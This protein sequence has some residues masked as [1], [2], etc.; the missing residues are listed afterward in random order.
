[1]K[2]IFYILWACYC[3]ACYSIGYQTFVRQDAGGWLLFITSPV[4]VPACYAASFLIYVFKVKK[5]HN[6]LLAAALTRKCLICSQKAI[7]FSSTYGD[8]CSTAHMEQF[9]GSS[10]GRAAYT[11]SFKPRS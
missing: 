1:M 7:I 4:T 6:D 9:K 2:T 8:F 10:L 3:S 11:E 5:D